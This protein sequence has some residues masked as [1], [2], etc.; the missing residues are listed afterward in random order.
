MNAK[1]KMRTS[2]SEEEE[3]KFNFFCRCIRFSYFQSYGILTILHVVEQYCLRGCHRIICESNSQVVVNLF[4]LQGF[5][6][7]VGL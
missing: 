7:L 1:R 3:E 2:A 5:Q 4:T 6:M